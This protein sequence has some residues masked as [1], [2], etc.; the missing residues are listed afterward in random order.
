MLVETLKHY[1]FSPLGWVCIEV[2]DIGVSKLHFVKQPDEDHVNPLVP[3]I[4]Q[5]CLQLDQYFDGSRKVF[6]LTLDWKANP[7]FSQ[8]VWKTL[9]DIP[10]GKTTTYGK[11]AQQIG[12]PKAAQA[13]GQANGLNP[14][15]IV[16]PCHRVVGSNGRLT[17]YAGGLDKKKWLLIHERD[18]SPKPIDQLF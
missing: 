6:D 13:V 2:T 11:L 14:I 10:Y 8:S 15:A 16:V 4:D 12:Q 5:C 18:H 3:L 7:D 17:G 1:H 9:L